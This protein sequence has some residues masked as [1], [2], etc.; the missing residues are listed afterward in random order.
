MRLLEPIAAIRSCFPIAVLF[1]VLPTS[2]ADVR[3]TMPVSEKSQATAKP[4]GP[5]LVVQLGHFRPI[6]CCTFSSDGDNI[7]TASDGEIIL[8]DRLTGRELR[9][10]EGH[11]RAVSSVAFSPDGRRVLTGSQDKTARLWDVA[12]GRELRRFEGNAAGVSAVAFSP[13]GRQVLT[14]S[15]DTARLWDAA[16]GNEVRRFEGHR[17]TVGSVAFSPDGRQVLTGGNDQTARLWDAVTGKELHRFEGLGEGST[18]S[19]TFSPDGRQVLLTG[20]WQKT[21]RLCDVSTGRELRRFEAR[22]GEFVWSATFAPDGRRILAAGRDKTAWIWDVATGKELRRYDAHAKAV[23]SVAFSPDGRQVLT[24]SWDK[25]ARL[26][27]AATGREFRRFEGHGIAVT[28]LAFSAGGRMILTAGEEKTARLWDATSGKGLRRFEEPDKPVSCVS[29]SADGRQ[30]LTGGAGND[31]IQTGAGTRIRVSGIAR[32]WDA[33][34]GKELRRFEG[35]QGEVISLAFSANGRQVLTGSTD[36]TARLW[37]AATGREL[38]RFE[39]HADS[40]FSVAFSPDGRQILTASGRKDQA[41]AGAGIKIW[42]S[43]I[44]R[45]WDAA[46]G[47]EL[48]RFEGHRGPVTSVAFSADGRQGLTGSTDKSARLWDATT[49]KELHRFDGHTK[50]VSAAAFS[51]DGRHVLTGSYDK[52]VRIWDAATGNAVRRF[53]GPAGVRGAVFSADGRRVAIGFSNG[54]VGSWNLVTGKGLVRIILL[55]QEQEWLAVTP[56]GYFDGSLAARQWVTW[57]I[58]N[59]VFPLELYESRFFRPDLVMRALPGASV[60]SEP[61]LPV[62]RTPPRVAIEIESTSPQSAAIQITAEAGS[63]KAAIASVRVTVDGRDMSSQRVR[64]LVRKRFEGRTAIY[65]A[66]VN[67]P[68]GK[69]DALVAAVASDDAGLQSHPA[70][71]RIQRPVPA[72]AVRGGLYVLVVGVSRYKFKDYNLAF[73]D[74]DAQELAKAFAGQKGRAF[75]NVETLSLVNEQATAPAVKKGLKW[76]AQSCGPADV[77]L[78]L[79]AGHGICGQR[80]L[81]YVTYEGD[82]DAL[83]ATCVNWTEVA[84]LLGNV[85]ARQVLFLSDCCHAGAFADRSA[86]TDQLAKPLIDAGVVVLAAGK[87]SE[88]SAESSDWGHGAFVYALLEGLQGK[89][90]LMKDGLITISALQAYTAARVR[91]LTDDRQHPQIPVAGNFELG[92][93]LAR[94]P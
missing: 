58:G 81:Y 14:A 54:T 31:R 10:F 83:Q 27:D 1:F 3:E 40:V 30:I 68:A 29:L 34:T 67:F 75:S 92:L 22:R 38:R 78:V 93:V 84:D 56:Q 46:T 66:V 32:L 6:E 25:T 35:H 79:F 43:G 73:P 65:R 2:A 94:V 33:A 64:D 90:D 5:E 82:L 55:K 13:D 42:T 26:W 60:E 63:E 17:S 80:G 50:L 59:Q 71:A 87:G 61:P 28:S 16:Q 24:G 41:Q 91:A 20:S 4:A 37:D 45:L 52:T 88:L 8:W 12:T 89:A 48:R 9:R 23:S 11:S 57:R 72:E 15:G 39:G 85:H 70:T 44:A 21:A 76:L 69:Q 18:F 53:H 51:P 74:A 7:L 77:A 36:R 86:S 62:D 19:G 47:M 49:G